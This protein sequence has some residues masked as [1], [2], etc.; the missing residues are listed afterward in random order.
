VVERL[1][2]TLEKENC[3][4]VRDKT[5]LRYGDLI[6]TFMKTLGQADWVIVVLSA[7]YLHSH[8]CMTELYDIYQ[9]ARQKSQEF[10]N[11]IIPL[12]LADARIGTWRD[13][14]AY[15]EYW[16]TEFRG[17]GTSKDSGG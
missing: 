2:R 10:L 15:A 16:E 14:V 9:N 3:Q 7:K 13:R 12:V 4:V 1:C 8:Y 11:R 6:S 5:A 17:Y